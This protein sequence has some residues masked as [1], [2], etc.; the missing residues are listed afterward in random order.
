MSQ[1]WTVKLGVTEIRSCWTIFL[2]FLELSH[3]DFNILKKQEDVLN[4][5]GRYYLFIWFQH[6]YFCEIE[7]LWIFR[8]S[9]WTG[10]F[11]DTQYISCL[12]LRRHRYRQLYY[13]T[14]TYRLRGFTVGINSWS[15]L[16]A[17]SLFIS[18]ALLS[19]IR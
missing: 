16:V 6:L 9:S 7:P 1:R 13:T 15:K 4:S 11:R 17:R 19:L 12:D 10:P 18:I 2:D 5:V 8:L 3:L 14:S